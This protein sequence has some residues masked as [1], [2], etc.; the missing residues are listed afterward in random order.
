MSDPDRIRLRHI[1][2]AATEALHFVAGRSKEALVADRQL[3]LALIKEIE[4]IGEAA[5]RI[6]IA[7][8]ESR[9][10]VPWAA[11][12]GMRNRLIHAYAEIWS[13]RGMVRRVFGFAFAFKDCAAAPGDVARQVLVWRPIS[14]PNGLRG[15][16]IVAQ[17]QCT[18]HH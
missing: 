9:P 18:N 2:D 10:D 7:L 5:S 17:P 15:R 11:T 14:T 12:I 8:K 3:A 13:R 1:Q 16:D 6:S 4:I